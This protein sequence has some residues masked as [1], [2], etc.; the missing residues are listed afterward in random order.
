[1]SRP[2][3]QWCGSDASA[4]APCSLAAMGAFRLVCCLAVV[5]PTLR[6]EATPAPAPARPPPPPLVPKGGVCGVF[7]GDACMEGLEC[8]CLALNRG[9]R[10]CL[11]PDW[12]RGAEAARRWERQGLACEPTLPSG[13]T[14]MEAPPLV[15][16]A[17]HTVIDPR[18]AD[19]PEP[20]RLWAEMVGHGF[21]SNY[22]VISQTDNAD[23]GPGVAVLAGDDVPRAVFERDLA[24]LRH[25]LL[26]APVEPTALLSAL[27]RAGVR[28]LIAGNGRGAWRKHPEIGQ[29]FATGL[30]GGAPWFPS[31]GVRIEDS[32]Q[33]L[34]EE[35][36]HTIQYVFMAPRLV[37]MY[38]NAY[39]AAFAAGL[40]TTD[41]SGEEVN[42]EPVPT[43]Q[44]DEY[45]AMAFRRW[46]GSTDSQDEYSV[47]GN[48]A[49]AN[50]REEL[51]RLDPAAFCLVAEIFRCDDAWN[52]EPEVMPWRRFPNRPMDRGEANAFCRS[53]LEGLAAGCPLPDTIWPTAT[54]SEGVL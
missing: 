17:A 42:G 18:A 44:A 15:A 14:P 13:A 3:R 21:Y 11:L 12:P 24:A 8:R 30:G 33:L 4:I 6:A 41:G 1:M 34:A 43:V 5:P 36:F 23:C 39:A 50:G 20:L 9:L 7:F 37:C 49:E 48:S 2:T 22:A 28:L 38:H 51:R 26:H 10:I 35:V 46:L 27:S 31:T 53:V 47:P 29:H 32:P 45:F 54:P 52:P 25:L 19:S 40:Y 16:T